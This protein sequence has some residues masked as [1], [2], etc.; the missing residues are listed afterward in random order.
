MDAAVKAVSDDGAGKMAT[1]TAQQPKVRWFRRRPPVG[2]P[3]LSRSV[4]WAGHSQ[5]FIGSILAIV[6]PV[7]LV[8]DL[9]PEV[10]RFLGP[11]GL[12]LIAMAAP[13]ACSGLMLR[14][15]ATEL[16]RDTTSVAFRIFQLVIVVLSIAALSIAFVF[17]DMLV[18][19]LITNGVVAATG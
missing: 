6:G 17:L 10:L 2:M 13:F 1:S 12:L 4:W 8:L 18:L 11:T 3:P 7:L 9:Q 15:F 19:I 14:R 16:G 5:L